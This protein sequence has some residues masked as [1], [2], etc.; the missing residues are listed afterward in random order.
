[1]G[2]GL[3]SLQ[4]PPCQ[5][6]AAAS[7]PWTRGSLTDA[8]GETESEGQVRAV[9]GMHRDPDL[10]PLWPQSITH[11]AELSVEDLDRPARKSSF[12]PL[13]PEENKK[14]DEHEVMDQSR[15]SFFFFCT[16]IVR[17]R[18]RLFNDCSDI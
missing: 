14:Q 12:S 7:K 6:A 8:M 16:D 4:L 5:E 3:S 15:V 13:T 9:S 11:Q 18:T 1:M 10:C 17:V 2:V